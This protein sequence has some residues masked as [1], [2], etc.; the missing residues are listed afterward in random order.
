MAHLTFFP[1]ELVAN[2]AAAAFAEHELRIR[3]RLSSVDIRHTGGTSVPG[4]LTSGDVDL[5]VRTGS[6]SFETAREILCEL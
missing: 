6:Q 2:E 3:E 4:V 1:S 5:Q